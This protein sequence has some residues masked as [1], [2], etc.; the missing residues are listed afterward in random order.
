MKCP[1]DGSELVAKKYEAEIE[2]D[3]CNSC[4]GTWLDKGELEA[5]QATIEKD[6]HAEL[7]QQKDTVKE[8][9]EA[10][11]QEKRGAVPCPKCATEM[12][13]RPYGMGSQVIIDVCPQGC[14]VWL[15]KGE[16]EALEK[17]FE[18]SQQETELPLTWRVWASVVSVFRNKK[19]S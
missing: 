8:G 3:L 1:R 6:Y 13:V 14:G 15:D 19:K 17:F 5:I 11:R 12:D 7:G 4:S 16:L 9:I 18:T 10:V 2:V